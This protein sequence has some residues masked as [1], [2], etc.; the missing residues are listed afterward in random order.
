MKHHKNKLHNFRDL[1]TMFGN[2][3]IIILI[4]LKRKIENRGLGLGFWICK[5]V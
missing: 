3:F 4:K 1:E 2:Y 5:Q